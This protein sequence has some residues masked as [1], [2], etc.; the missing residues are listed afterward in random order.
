MHLVP[1]PVTN[2]RPTC[3]HICL[4]SLEMQPEQ[5]VHM[6]KGATRPN[7]SRHWLYWVGPRLRDAVTGFITEWSRRNGS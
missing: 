4:A 7:I 6:V 3:R 2:H 5:H 1:D